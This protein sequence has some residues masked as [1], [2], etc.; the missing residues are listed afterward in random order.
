MK[1]LVI[2]QISQRISNQSQSCHWS[3]CSRNLIVTIHGNKDS[4]L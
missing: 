1:N 2:R 3:I 4:T